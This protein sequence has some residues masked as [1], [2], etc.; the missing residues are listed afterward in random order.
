MRAVFLPVGAVALLAAGI[1]SLM[2]KHSSFSDADDHNALESK[3]SK[4]KGLAAGIG[5]RLLY[6]LFT[7]HVN[8][9]AKGGFFSIRWFNYFLGNNEDRCY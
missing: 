5:S 6:K 7:K 2:S 1:G 4:N 3:K 8:L 9:R